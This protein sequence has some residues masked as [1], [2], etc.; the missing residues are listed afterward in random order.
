MALYG[1]KSSGAAFRSFLV[2]RLVEMG[3]NSIIVD[4]DVW[5]GPAIKADGEHHYEF[6]LVYFD[7]LPVI[8]QY[9]VSVIREVAE[10]FKLKKDKIEQPKIYLRGRLVRKKLIGNQVWTI[11]SVGYF[12]AVV[13]NLE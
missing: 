4:L 5:I 3:F 7:D 12:K 2:E 6:I 9:S 11:S 10:K 13:N 1:L 8:I